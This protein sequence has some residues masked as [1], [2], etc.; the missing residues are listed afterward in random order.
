MEEWR[1]IIGYEG[2]YQIS[3]LGRVKSLNYNNTGKEG[4]RELDDDKYGYKVIN[5]YKNG[6]GKRY[7]VHRLVAI[8]F[9]PNP[10]NLPQVN[11]INEIKNDNRVENLE[12]CTNEYNHN[13]G[14]RNKRSGESKSKKVKCITTGEIFRSSTEGSKK[15]KISP[16]LIRRCCRGIRKSAGKHPVTGEKLVWEYI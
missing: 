12:W 1:D 15:Y 6:K 7:S 3:N 13:Y 16:S 5:L 11:H 14:T 8:A 4:L 2:I 9:I 10:N